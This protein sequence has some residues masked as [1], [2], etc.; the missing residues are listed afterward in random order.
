VLL[1]IFTPLHAPGQLLHFGSIAHILV[2]NETFDPV[3]CTPT[4]NTH[5]AV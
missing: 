1:F 4:M 5:P 2:L 3:A